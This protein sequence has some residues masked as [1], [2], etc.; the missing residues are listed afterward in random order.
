MDMECLSENGY[1][2]NEILHLAMLDTFKW[3]SGCD[4]LMLCLRKRGLTSG[5]RIFIPYGSLS[6][7]LYCPKS[8]RPCST[9][10]F[11]RRVILPENK[12]FLACMTL[13]NPFTRIP[14]P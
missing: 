6:Q 8:R 2:G 7:A 3:R 14:P 9:T 4:D 1:E 12:L 10:F 13:Y 5:G 11:R